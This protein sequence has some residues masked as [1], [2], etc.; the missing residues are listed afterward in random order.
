MSLS[1]EDASLKLKTCI[2]PRGQI[3]HQPLLSANGRVRGCC[4]RP[5]Q[6]PTHTW[7]P[8]LPSVLSSCSCRQQLWPH[9][10]ENPDRF[11]RAWVREDV[12]CAAGFSR[13]LDRN[14][15]GGPLTGTA[16]NFKPD[17]D[18]GRAREGG[19]RLDHLFFFGAM[20]FIGI[21]WG[22]IHV[23]LYGGR[24]PGPVE[25]VGILK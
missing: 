24:D 17:M 10:F 12:G 4:G 9:L 20:D 6:T 1:I 21:D 7:L 11:H 13:T 15:I 3:Q 19:R 18:M 2:R 14:G 16:A 22:D 8:L 25:A 23:V 5:L